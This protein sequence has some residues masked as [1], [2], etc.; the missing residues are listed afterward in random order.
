MRRA[1][2]LAA[3]AGVALLPGAALAH[4]AA[5]DKPGPSTLWTA[6]DLDPIAILLLLLSSW[7]YWLGVGKVNRE[8]PASPYPR[9]RVAFFVAAQVSIVIALLSPVAYYDT[10]LFSVHMVQHLI[11]TMISAPLFIL[12]TPLTL[13]LRAAS[14]RVRRRVLL[15]ILHSRVVGVISFPVVAW[16]VFA[17]T[18]WGSHFSPLYE[19]SLEN[20]WIHRGE[21][22]LYLSAALLFWWQVVAVDPTRWRMNHPVRLLYLFLQMPQN[23]F[24][25][26]AIYSSNTVMYDHYLTLARDWGPTPLNDQQMAG[27][28]MWVVGDLLFITA[29]AFVAYGWVKHEE[30]EAKRVDR[31][32]ARERAERQR[33]GTSAG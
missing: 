23:S 10:T 7:L 19:E 16:L 32:L 30:R 12:S 22:I 18:M 20:V 24:L 31:R 26:V 33:A 27:I 29:M 2:W 6:W 9:K 8:H 4:G 21:H 25:G 3:A 1:S 13:A 17:A 28:I 14:P 5:P 11:L 15:P